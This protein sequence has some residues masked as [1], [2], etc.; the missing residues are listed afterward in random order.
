MRGLPVDG[1]GLV[2]LHVLAGLDAAAAEDALVGI[3]PIEGIGHVLLVWFGSVLARLVLYV[4]FG[5]GV[6]DGAVLVV[7]VADRAIEH[8]VLQDAVEGR[9]SFAGSPAAALTLTMQVSQ[10]WMGPIWR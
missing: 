7:V 10:L 3:I 6:V 2:D 4:E 8:V 5:G 9:T 1:E